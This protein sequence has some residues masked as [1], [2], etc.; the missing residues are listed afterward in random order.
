MTKAGNGLAQKLLETK[1]RNESS[2]L[3]TEWIIKV[4]LV[5]R[6][7]NLSK[8]RQLP[9]RVKAEPT[10]SALWKSSESCAV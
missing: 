5:R 4:L 8:E 6:A 3:V 7:A 1:R 9:A 2:K 10:L